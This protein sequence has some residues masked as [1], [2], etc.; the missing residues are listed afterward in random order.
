MATVRFDPWKTKHKAPFGAIVEN[1][2]A[3]FTIEVMAASVVSVKMIM[4]KDF[5]Q[6][7]L[8]TMRS[9][10]DRC[11]TCDYFFNQG[12]GLYFY[13]FEIETPT[14]VEYFG[15]SDMGGQGRICFSPEQVWEYQVTCYQKG[16][17]APDW[18][19]DGIF[20]QIF[21]DRFA[22]GNTDGRINSPK[23][24][25]F[26]Y[27]TE[28]D[29]PLYVKDSKGEI[30]RWDFFGGN[31]KGI[32]QK[33]PYLKELGVNGIYLNPVFAANS[34]H[35]YDT[36]DYFAVDPV[37]GTQEDFRQLIDALH[38]NGM[39]LILDG[40]FSHV[41]QH[42]RYFNVDQ[43][44]GRY[45]GAYNNRHSRYYSWFTFED[46]PDSYASWWGIKDLPEINKNDPDYQQFIY[47]KEDSVLTKWNQF[48]V[49]GW[50]LD[51]ADELPDDFIKGIR[52][53]L[54]QFSDKVL[55]GEVWE[56]ASN[57]I[58]YRK[59][60]NYILG[61]HLQGVMNYP[62][63][64]SVLNLLNE[65]KKPKEVA[66]YLMTLYENYPHDIFYNNL[67]NIGT[68]D[69]ERIFSQLNHHLQKLDLAFGMMFVFPG[70]PCIYYGDEAGLTGG[71]DPE[72]RKF[73]PWQSI[74][75]NIQD[76]CRKWIQFRKKN[77]VLKEGRLTFFY[78]DSLFGILRYDDE[79]YVALLLNPGNYP[80]SCD[81]DLYFMG[82]ET[83][84]TQEVRRRLSDRTLKEN[85]YLLVTSEQKRKSIELYQSLNR[86]HS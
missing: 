67:N 81:G 36:A 32:Q 59:R 56:D 72:N 16:D 77:E 39:H 19:K 80:A 57:K 65:D 49:D 17:Q 78:T 68:H 46:Y 33:I 9:Q 50:R 37:L 5:G 10:G 7:Q 76:D 13:H 34:N 75:R 18:Y 2:F 54:D 69:T 29:D 11:Y 42:S 61:A 21:P 35:R 12:I 43:A 85:S 70:I 40:V 15:P 63:R 66:H 22:N 20:Y 52:E 55:L 14:H 58:S 82:D 84:L 38:E 23:K 53:N 51:V 74:D 86:T 79:E 71:K 83:P 62:L 27:A 3:H 26:V 28:E 25:S 30:L 24:N 47:G 73:F 45:S 44:Y 4:H 1:E 41:G 48:G 31:F 64:N 8:L 6:K 60:R